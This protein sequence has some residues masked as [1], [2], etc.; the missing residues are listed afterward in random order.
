MSVSQQNLENI[1]IDGLIPVIL[2]IK[3]AMEVPLIAQMVNSP[4][5]QLAKT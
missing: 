4:P 3:P 1:Y 5:A 2:D